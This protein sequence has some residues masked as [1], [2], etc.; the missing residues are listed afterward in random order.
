MKQKTDKAYMQ[1]VPIK[2]ASYQ[3]DKKKNKG[4]KLHFHG[5]DGIMK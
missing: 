5:V 2:K 3:L 4:R 1:I